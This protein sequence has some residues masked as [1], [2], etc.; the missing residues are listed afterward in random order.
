MWR[1]CKDVKPT[2]T[3]L[4]EKEVICPSENAGKALYV[5]GVRD[6][7]PTATKLREKDIICPSENGYENNWHLFIRSNVQKVLRVGSK[8]NCGTRWNHY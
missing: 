5:E 8:A 1:V 3:R 7:K 2:T 6:V 4:R